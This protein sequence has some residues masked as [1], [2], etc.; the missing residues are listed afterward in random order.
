M[1]KPRRPTRVIT[2]RLTEEEHARVKHEAWM[3]RL[4]MN[5]FVLNR[6]VP[7]VDANA[8]PESD[9]SR[10]ETQITPRTG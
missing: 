5:Q 2:V 6:L 8:T 3:E 7:P 4:S 10:P 9:Q 1:S